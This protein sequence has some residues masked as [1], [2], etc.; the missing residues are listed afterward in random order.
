[1]TT[2][3]SSFSR[4][5]RGPVGPWGR[6]SGQQERQQEDLSLSWAS[7]ISRDPID[8][9]MF[10]SSSDTQDKALS[11]SGFWD[12]ERRGQVQVTLAIAL[13]ACVC[14]CVTTR[15]QRS[16]LTGSRASWRWCGRSCCAAAVAEKREPKHLSG[17][18]LVPGGVARHAAE[19]GRGGNHGSEALRPPPR[20]RSRVHLASRL[21]CGPRPA[22]SLRSVD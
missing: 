6:R 16:G 19:L 13:W 1:M 11:C 5:P 9:C 10:G 21:R 3:C 14:V 8:T 7:R 17:H 2:W 22:P 12:H 4:R 15:C 20:S 18:G